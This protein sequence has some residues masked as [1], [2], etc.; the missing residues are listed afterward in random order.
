MPQSSHEAGGGDLLQAMTSRIEPDTRAGLALVVRFLHAEIEAMRSAGVPVGEDDYRGLYISDR[1]VDRLLES[2]LRPNELAPVSTITTLR[3]YLDELVAN[4]TGRLRSVIELGPLTAFETGCLLLCLAGETD[5]AVERLLAYAQDDVTRRRP[6]VDLLLRLFAEPGGD[7]RDAWLPAA[8]LR[9]ERMVQL[10]DEPGQP[11]TPLSSRSVALDPRIAEFLLGSDVFC[12]PLASHAT[13]ANQEDP[14]A[15]LLPESIIAASRGLASLA[16]AG[17]AGPVAVCGTDPRLQRAAAS[18]VAATCGAPLLSIDYGKLA[19]DPSVDGA[20]SLALREARLRNAVLLLE[21]VSALDAPVRNDLAARLV[22]GPHVLAV[23][24]ALDAN[25]I[26]PGLRMDIPELDYERRRAHWASLLLDESPH[27]APEVEGVAAKFR[28]GVDEIGRAAGHARSAVSW[29]AAAG[30]AVLA[31]LSAAARGQS[32]PILSGLAQKISSPY[33]WDDLVLPEDALAQLREISAQVEHRHR[34][35][36]AWGFARRLALSSGVVALFAGNSGTGKTMAA[37]IMANSLGLDL[38][39]IDLS[40]VVS[41]YIG[42]TEKNLDA[43]FREAERSNAVLFF[44]EADALFGKRSE[45]KD[46]HDRYANIETAFLL[47]RMEEYSGI[48]TLSTNLKMNLDEAFIRRLH[49]VVDFPMPDEQ[50][51]RRIWQGAVPPEAP[52]KGQIDWDFLARQFK[53][54]G[55]N[56]KNAV[57]AAAFLA[58]ADD[59]SIGMEHFA[60]GIRREYQKLGRMVTDAEFGPYS[61]L[62]R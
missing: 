61:A 55:G 5:P 40:A 15:A 27:L 13:I 10:F 26:W 58:V 2:G 54:S 47:Q 50:H 22:S 38:Y 45:V 3:S 6:R 32:T 9:R 1:E 57:V 42:E 16:L 41:K 48:V 44:D 39:R 18:V 43:V 20:L 33:A 60:R 37:G 17:A 52:I 53:I 19:S 14:A 4:A 23:L 49:F 28:L 35:Y 29:Q 51:R 25:G 46:A 30:G 7:C 56:I 62:L 8:P 59:E 21:N 12:E 11:F 31:D 36:E 34:V 24:V